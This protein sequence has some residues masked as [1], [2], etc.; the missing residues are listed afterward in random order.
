MSSAAHAPPVDL[1]RKAL[2]VLFWF[3]ALSLLFNSLFG[4]MGLIQGYRQRHLVARLQQEVRTLRQG[5]DRLAGDISDLRH[6]PYRI[7]QIAREEL[8]LSRPGEILF[9]FQEP[10]PGATPSPAR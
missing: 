8:G 9:L 5:N 6:D 4:D 2:L 1:R 7:E 10:E 3:V